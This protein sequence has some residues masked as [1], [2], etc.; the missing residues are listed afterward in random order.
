MQAN[1]TPSLDDPRLGTLLKEG[2]EGNVTVIGFPYDIG[3]KRA[4]KPYGQEYGPGLLSISTFS[5]II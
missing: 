1:P 3:A 5:Y 4:G 2:L